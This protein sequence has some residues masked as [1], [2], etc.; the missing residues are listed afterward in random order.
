MCGHEDDSSVCLDDFDIDVV[1][2]TVRMMVSR[3]A[4]RDMNVMYNT[5]VEKLTARELV[6]KLDAY[7]TGRVADR[8]CIDVEYPADWWEAFK[9][10]WFP[11]FMLK[12]WPVKMTTIKVDETRFVMCPHL[13]S[14]PKINHYRWLQ[15][16]NEEIQH[17][18]AT[19][20]F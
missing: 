8:I 9:D 7:I 4:I 18:K 6:L 20:R 5:S 2:S 15:D 16:Y 1:R 12:R 13:P 3:E 14:E 11:N 17:R 19:K 10:R